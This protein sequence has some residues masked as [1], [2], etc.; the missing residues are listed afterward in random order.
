MS[1]RQ[2]I[3]DADLKRRLETLRSNGLLH[4][5]TWWPDG[6]LLAVSN[7]EYSEEKGNSRPFKVRHSDRSVEMYA[8]RRQR[9]EAVMREIGYKHFMMGMGKDG[10][11]WWRAKTNCYH[12]PYVPKPR[13]PMPPRPKGLGKGRCKKLRNAWFKRR[14]AEDPVF[15]LTMRV[16]AAIHQTLRGQQK[17][18]PTWELLGYSPD[19][20]KAHLEARF[21]EGMSWESYGQWHIDHIRPLS[22]FVITGPNCPELRRAWALENLQP[23][24]AADNIRKGARWAA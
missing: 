3:T 5:V 15:R 1:R 11:V 7:E 22:S 19:Q 10:S 6:G 24:W 18:R 4:F 16:R 9:L 23:L 14:A 12:P 8:R 13:K 2:Q 20:L 21:S 17:R